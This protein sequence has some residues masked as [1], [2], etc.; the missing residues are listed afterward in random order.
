MN[1]ESI[2][3]LEQDIKASQKRPPSPTPLANGSLKKDKV[4][5]ERD[6]VIIVDKTFVG[7]AIM[8]D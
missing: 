4:D 2:L 6:G 1:R 3:L 8:I 5:D 7:E